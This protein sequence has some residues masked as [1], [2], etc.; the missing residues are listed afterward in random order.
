M[1]RLVAGA[2][3]GA[4]LLVGCGAAPGKQSMTAAGGD[5]AST[6]PLIKSEAISA[7]SV[8]SDAA[9]AA[10]STPQLIRRAQMSLE[11]DDA[12]ATVQA[13]QIL[14]QQQQ[15]DILQ[16]QERTLPGDGSP[17]RASL[18]LRVPQARLD[19][20]LDELSNLGLVENRSIT[21]EDV[22]SQMVDTAARLRNLR[23]QEEMVLGIME[24]SGEISEVLEVSNQLATVRQSIEQLDAQLQLLKNQVAYSTIS[25]E[26][27]EP[28]AAAASRRSLGSEMK[29]AWNG[30]SNSAGAFSRGLL[31]MGLWL[32][33]YSPYLGAIAA[34][35]Y[36]VRRSR[37]RA[38]HAATPVPTPPT[39][40]T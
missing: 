12:V 25:L 33:A 38:M 24:R 9:V 19:A 16:L 3:I 23:K 28:L 36:W 27:A 5:A 22:S 21:A 13:I 7:E 39:S 6:A 37:R 35:I 2:V 4:A 26:L 20:T 17:R 29:S 14:V 30:A 15:G 18:E 10:V 8:E 40:Q 32:L 1:G 31:V 11:V 34:G